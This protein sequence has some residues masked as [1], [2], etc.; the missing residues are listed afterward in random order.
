MCAPVPGFTVAERGRFDAVDANYAMIER[1]GLRL[2]RVSRAG[3][4]A[5]GIERAKR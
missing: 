5:T 4:A 2:E 1:G 3:D